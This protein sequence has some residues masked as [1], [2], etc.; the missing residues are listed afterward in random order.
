MPDSKSN[1][2][3]SSSEYVNNEAITNAIDIERAKRSKE[4]E[5]KYNENW[6]Q[7]MVNINE[8]VDKFCP[9][10]VGKTVSCVKFVYEN[11]NYMIECDKVA[12]YLRIYDKKAKRYVK[13][14]GTP[15]SSEETHL[16]IKKREE[17]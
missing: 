6:K 9:D 14:D 7:N 3:L 2:S 5:E 4:R 11:E 12:G 13:A 10:V 17:M 16:K 1:Y 15:G 8:I